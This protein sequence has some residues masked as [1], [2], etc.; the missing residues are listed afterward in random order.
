[1]P[2]SEGTVYEPQGV[3]V[4]GDVFT[5]ISIIIR[6]KTN[7]NRW[8]CERCAVWFWH[9]FDKIFFSLFTINKLLSSLTLKYAK[10][11]EK[12]RNYGGWCFL[13]S[14][15]SYAVSWCCFVLEI[16]SYD[17]NRTFSKPQSKKSIKF[18]NRELVSYESKAFIPE[19]PEISE[20]FS[21]FNVLCNL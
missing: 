21:F 3:F 6:Q 9:I 14:C 2:D 20:F 16:R 15:Y 7:R 12:C 11:I 19:I 4:H 5:S 10:F 8:R 17:F 13:S 1:M 18:K